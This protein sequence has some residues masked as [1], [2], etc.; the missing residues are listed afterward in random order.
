MLYFAEVARENCSLQ[1]RNHS[2]P[3][4]P[5]I[6]N[7]RSLKTSGR[8]SLQCTLLERPFK[9]A[10]LLCKLSCQSSFDEA[11]FSTLNRLYSKSHTP[12]TFL[13]TP[14]TL[15]PLSIPRAGM[16]HAPSS[17]HVLFHYLHITPIYL[18]FVFHCPYITP[19]Y[20]SSFYFLFHYPNKTPIYYSSFPLSLYN[21]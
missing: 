21:T 1:C 11:H 12:A 7:I 9:T 17:F 3:P 4:A 6:Q 14:K 8:C 19:I 13:H 5:R 20:Y 2:R 16:S 18:H 10:P 15:C